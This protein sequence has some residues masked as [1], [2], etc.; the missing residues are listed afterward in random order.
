MEL[1]PLNQ[2]LVLL[3]HETEELEDSSRRMA[4]V[5]KTRSWHSRSHN[6]SFWQ[7]SF[8]RPILSS[9]I[10]FRMKKLLRSCTI[11]LARPSNSLESLFC[12]Q[13]LSLIS[14]NFGQYRY[15]NQRLH[16]FW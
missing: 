14:Q 2:V 15:R 5:I 4:D 10:L 1:L 9:L 7:F 12:L 8:C 3:R 16:R 13:I 11:E 6:K